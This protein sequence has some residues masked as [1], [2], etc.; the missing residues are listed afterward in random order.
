MKKEEN[1]FMLRNAIN[2]YI[3]IAS[4]NGELIEDVMDDLL[5]IV[6]NIIDEAYNNNPIRLKT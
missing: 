1:E 2:N 3:L 4:K 5:E 6:S